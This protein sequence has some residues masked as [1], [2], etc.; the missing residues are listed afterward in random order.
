MPPDWNGV[1]LLETASE[2]GL[3]CQT[4]TKIGRAGNPFLDLSSF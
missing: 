3:L 1:T 4:S 2:L